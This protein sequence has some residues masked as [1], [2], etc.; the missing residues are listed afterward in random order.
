LPAFVTNSSLAG[1]LAALF[2]GATLIGVLTFITRWRGQSIGSEEKLR[3]DMG[4]ELGALRK[5]LLELERHYRDMLRESDRRHEECQTDRT[6]LQERVRHLENE[7]NGLHRQI[8][9]YSSER[10]LELDN[11][12]PSA[13]VV[14]AARRVKD[15]NGTQ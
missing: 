9:R 10:V 12:C 3:E 11:D 2:S 15:N 13:K 5:Q 14:A 6:R 8:A 1:T 4:R 7:V